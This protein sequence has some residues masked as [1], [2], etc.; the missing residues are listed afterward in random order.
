MYTESQLFCVCIFQMF[1]MGECLSFSP[2]PWN[3]ECEGFGYLYC[4]ILAL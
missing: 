1:E 2:S 4:I 3:F